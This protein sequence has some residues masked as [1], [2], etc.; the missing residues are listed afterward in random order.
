VCYH[1]SALIDL[2]GAMSLPRGLS[3]R[4][5]GVFHKDKMKLYQLF[6]SEEEAQAYVVKMGSKF[7]V[8]VGDNIVG[9]EHFKPI[10]PDA[11]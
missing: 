8:K 4:R 5:W 1:A 6:D 7:V 3:V 11:H 2:G 10:E 9:T